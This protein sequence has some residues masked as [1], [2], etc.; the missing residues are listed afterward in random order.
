MFLSKHK[1]CLNTLIIGLIAL[2]LALPDS[3][4][5]QRRAPEGNILQIGVDAVPG[6]GLNP[7]V[8]SLRSV[9]TREVV[10]VSNLRS[11][12]LDQDEKARVALLAGVSL[13]VFGLERL[14]GYAGYRG[15][16]LDI[17]LRTGPGLTFSTRDTRVDKNR[18]FVLLVVPYTRFSSALKNGRAVYVEAGTVNPYLRAGIWLPLR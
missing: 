6:Y 12:V 14:I 8:V 1:D 17:G 7:G 2:F 18:R 13:R 5:A 11:V 9:Y 3:A 4:F 15:F 10:L 16:D